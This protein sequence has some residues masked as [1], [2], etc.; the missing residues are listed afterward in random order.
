MAKL[1]NAAYNQGVL[2]VAAA[3]NDVSCTDRTPGRIPSCFTVAA[4][5]RADNREFFSNWGPCVDAFVPG[6]DIYSA[7]VGSNT[8]TYFLL[9]G[10]SMATPHVAGLVAYLRAMRAEAPNISAA[11]TTQ[12][13]K[14]LALKGVIK[15]PRGSPNLLINNNSGA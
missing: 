7:S 9:S 8:S 14:D 2:G 10:T 11:A 1:I 15:D 13:I 5:D 4:S 12:R 3:G 6:F